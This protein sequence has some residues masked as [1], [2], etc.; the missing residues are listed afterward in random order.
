[1]LSNDIMFKILVTKMLSLGLLSYRNQCA[2]P[3]V[4]AKPWLCI[5]ASTTVISL[6]DFMSNL[7]LSY[8]SPF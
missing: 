5:L 3:F 2:V 7:I 1:M 6:A 8:D 4:E